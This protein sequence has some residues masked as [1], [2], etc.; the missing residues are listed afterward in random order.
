[1]SGD[2]ARGDGCVPTGS[3]GI[4]GGAAPA[5]AALLS[6][7]RRGKTLGSTISASHRL[8]SSPQ[9]VLPLNH[10]CGNHR[11][12][13]PS[14]RREERSDQAQSGDGNTV[15]PAYL[16]VQPIA[17]RRA[18]TNASRAHIPSDEIR[19]DGA[20]GSCSDLPG[21]PEALSIGH[22]I[23]QRSPSWAIGQTAL[24]NTFPT[25]QL[26]DRPDWCAH[27]CRLTRQD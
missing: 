25:S 14:S 4:G 7:V 15:T 10:S 18:H 21:M 11:L 24:R 22:R 23:S 9:S 2:T 20:P 13:W 12:Q 16:R 8:S 17:L 19:R 1:M 27:R 6:K 5:T 26:R 3:A